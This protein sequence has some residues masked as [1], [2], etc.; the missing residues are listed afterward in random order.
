MM[1][2]MMLLM[3]P[4]LPIIVGLLLNEAKPKKNIVVG[5]TLPF[6]ARQSEAVR[7]ILAS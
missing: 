2:L 5:V 7:T 6:E 3:Y 1:W 4:V